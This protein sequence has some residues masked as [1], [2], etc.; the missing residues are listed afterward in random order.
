MVDALDSTNH[1]DNTGDRPDYAVKGTLWLD[2]DVS[3]QNLALKLFTGLADAVLFNINDQTGAVTHIWRQVDLHDPTLNHEAHETFAMI[4]QKGNITEYIASD[5]DGSAGVRAMSTST[6]GLNVD[7]KLNIG[8]S[9]TTNVNALSVQPR[10]NGGV[11]FYVTDA[12]GAST[13]NILLAPG[14]L[15]GGVYQTSQ[16]INAWFYGTN[17]SIALVDGSSANAETGLYVGNPTGDYW[18]ALGNDGGGANGAN[19]Y[20]LMINRQASNSNFAAMT[21]GGVMAMRVSSSGQVYGTGPYVDLS[22]A[23]TK[24]VSDDLG[25]VTEDA[26]MGLKVRRFKRDGGSGWEFGYVA[27]EVESVIPSAVKSFEGDSYKD[28]AKIAR[29]NYHRMAFGEEATKSVMSD[30]AALDA[31]ELKGL[32]KDQINALLLDHVQNLTRR[33]QT[34]ENR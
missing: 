1:G 4:R 20:A 9:E 5:T 32:D 30:I 24:E 11:Q 6:F 33:I 31:P 7:G 10:V 12:A 21:I 27:G 34:L 25:I 14:K 15:T 16:S 8:Y 28:D 29:G 18:A 22:D 13:S 19:R 2:G 17:S 26:V 3:A 23:S